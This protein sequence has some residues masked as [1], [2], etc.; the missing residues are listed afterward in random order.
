MISQTA[1]TWL[2]AISTCAQNGGRR[3]RG[4]FGLMLITINPAQ[5]CTDLLILQ[6][7]NHFVVYR[8]RE[9]VAHE[10]SQMLKKLRLRRSQRAG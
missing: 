10:R 6:T 5:I 2:E 4:T 3:L 8:A 9:A 7:P 1:P